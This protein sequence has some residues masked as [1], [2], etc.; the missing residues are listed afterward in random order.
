MFSNLNEL[1]LK[2]KQIKMG[3][4]II[5]EHVSKIK[6]NIS[7]YFPEGLDLYAQLILNPFSFD[8]EALLDHFQETFCDFL[9][10]TSLEE[11]FKSPNIE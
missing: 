2:T 11:S 10:D 4:I 6:K 3:K 8:I 9:S 5:K 1:K 7:Y